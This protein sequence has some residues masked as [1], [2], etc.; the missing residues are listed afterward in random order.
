MSADQWHVKDTLCQN[1]TTGWCLLSEGDIG[2]GDG[3]R[4]MFKKE[5]QN[6]HV[7]PDAPEGFPGWVVP[8]ALHANLCE[9]S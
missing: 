4:Q 3:V 6:Y 7:V 9:S 2:Y 1:S 8:L 5:V